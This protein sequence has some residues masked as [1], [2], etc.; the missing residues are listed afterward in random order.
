MHGTKLPFRYWYIAM[1]LLT[2]TKKSFSALALQRQLGHEFYEPVWNIL[3]KLRQAMGS[4]DE[5][6]KLEGML[7]L[8]DGFFSTDV[9]EE[10]KEEPLKRGRVSQKKVKYWLMVESEPVNDE[11]SKKGKERKVRYIKMIVMPDLKSDTVTPLVEKSVSSSAKIDSDD[12]TSYTKL[13]EV[14]EGHHPQV[15]SK[16]KINATLPWVHIAISNAKRMLLDIYHHIR[17]EHLQSYL[18]E[19][20][21]KF[22]RIHQFIS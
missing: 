19:F 18:N 5:Q 17:S 8:D 3:H 13:S 22:N 7:E 12:S 2:S 21:Y 14:V 16:E 6:Y 4:R 15:V 10:N 9:E 1:H 11:T 20:C